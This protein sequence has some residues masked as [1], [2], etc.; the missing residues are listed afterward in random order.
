ML[1]LA[2]KAARHGGLM[3]VHKTVRRR[4]GK[5]HRQMYHVKP[6]Q[7]EAGAAKLLSRALALAE[8]MHSGQTDK[9]GE[10][11]MQHVKRVVDG[12]KHPLAKIVAALHDT[13]EDTSLD[14]PTI[15]RRFGKR[16][17]DA[18]R[19]LTR[20]KDESYREHLERVAADP[21]ASEVKRADLRDN[22]NLK[23]LPTVTDRD[24]ERVAKYAQALKFLER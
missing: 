12:V 3:P 16:V 11:Y 10:P 18:V 24:R 9:A 23:R 8:K 7:G 17:S 4:T 5:T 1:D 22:M 20:V 14:L 2:I 6:D 15:R 21:L 13:V 19:T